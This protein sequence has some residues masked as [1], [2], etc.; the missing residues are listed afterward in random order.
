MNENVEKMISNLSTKQ[1]EEL[2]KLIYEFISKKIPDW[3]IEGNDVTLLHQRIKLP[4][5]ILKIVLEEDRLK[6]KND[7]ADL[8]YLSPSSVSL[9]DKETKYNTKFL[10]K[11][12]LSEIDFSEENIEN[13]DLSDTN[14]KLNLQKMKKKSLYLTN[15]RGLDLSSAD[16][17]GV[18][19][20][21]ANLEGT[22]AKINPQVVS[23]KSL[24]QTNC[25]GLDLSSADFTGVDIEYSNL[26]G[27]R[28]KINPQVLFRKSLHGT[29]C[30]GLDLSS[31]DFTGVYIEGSNLEGTHA[32][33]NPQVLFRKSL[34][35]TNC[36]G[37]DLSS[38]DF[39]DIDIR[40]S[41][42]EKTNA[43]IDP[44]MVYKKSLEQ[45]NCRGLRLESKNFQGVNVK[46]ANLENTGVS[47]VL[48]FK[49]Y[50]DQFIL[51]K[52]DTFEKAVSIS[53]GQIDLSFDYLQKIKKMNQNQLEKIKQLI[54]NFIMEQLPNWDIL[55]PGKRVALPRDLLQVVFVDTN[56]YQQV[57]VDILR[58]IDFLEVDFKNKNMKNLDLS[59]TNIKINPQTIKD[60]SLYQT[61]CEGLNF[62]SADFTGVDVRGANLKNT[63]ASFNPQTLYKRSLYQTKCGDIDF[64]GACFIGV[65]V[66]ESDVSIP[67][68]NKN[69][70]KKRKP[71]YFVQ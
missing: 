18:Y 13:W 40:K 29:N 33:I 51:Q 19:I 52:L 37:L 11:L 12:D 42:L 62:S 69:N 20:E 57:S 17:T 68:R 53:D 49:S 8:E 64:T 30:Q 41:N 61:N 26:E 35:G 67:K 56:F 14:I 38:A 24:Y 47:V 66:R 4:L 58:R 39:T 2:G 1:K 10:R 55:T 9:R 60:K 15:C 25:R 48:D 70:I 34:Y 44:Q 71:I 59:Y 54:C 31:A 43:N 45:T 28:A 22:H 27:T 6:H 65:D 50:V 36:Q 16:F 23:G 32:K 21:G 46:G 3:D 63:D 5:D 7:V